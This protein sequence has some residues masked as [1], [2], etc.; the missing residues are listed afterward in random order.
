MVISY[1]HIRRRLSI[2]VS[3][4]FLLSYLMT[5]FVYPIHNFSHDRTLE[6]ICLEEENACHLRL[7]HNNV[8]QGC[9]HELHLTDFLADCDLCA[10][11][12]ITPDSE[13]DKWNY[14]VYAS[15]FSYSLD[16]YAD[17]PYS[18]FPNFR[19]KRGPPINS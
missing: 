14:A 12:Q 17:T 15:L 2:P 1:V 9:D 19:Y 13:L 3:T 4:L 11:L 10:L 18:L 16:D 7:I 8:E 5:L 6:E